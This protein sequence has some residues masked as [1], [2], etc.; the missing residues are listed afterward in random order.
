MNIKNL[1][2][3]SRSAYR[4]GGVGLFGKRLLAFLYEKTFAE[5]KI[6][7]DREL[8]LKPRVPPTRIEFCGKVTEIGYHGKYIYSEIN[9]KVIP[10]KGD[11]VFEAGVQNGIDTATFGK[12]ADSVVGFEPSPRNYCKAKRNLK[13]FENIDIINEGLWK[14]KDE[15]EIRY[16]KKPRDDGFLR[17]DEDSG[18]SVGNVPVNTIESYSKE[19]GIESIDFLKIEAEGAEPEIIE[20]MGDLRPRNIVVNAA[21]ERDGQPTGAKVMKLLQPMGYNLVGVKWGHILFFTTE[22]VSHCAFRSEFRRPV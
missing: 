5:N 6:L 22:D 19:L 12:F 21:E 20:G 2:T 14:E 17:P 3:S 11:I 10:K 18:E 16:G 8:I 4:E 7:T 1:I 9:H 15:I 13:Y